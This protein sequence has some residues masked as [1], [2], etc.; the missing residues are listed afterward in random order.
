MIVEAST[1][2]RIDLAGGTLDIYP[3]Y[4][5]EGGAITVN[6]AIDLLSYVKIEE[7]KD[8]KFEIHSEDLNIAIKADNLTS[9]DT[10]KELDL[11]CRAVKY[12]S[13]SKG[14]NIYTKNSVPK[15]SGL[16]ASSSLLMALSGAL[17]IITGKNYNKEQIIDFGA[18]IEAQSLKIPT[19][20][21]DYYAAIYGGLNAICFNMDKVI[22]KPLGNKNI[23]EKL[24]DMIILSYTGESRFSGTN[25]WEMMKRYIDRKEN[26]QENMKN[27]K[28]TSEKMCQAILEEDFEKVAFLINEEWE[29]RKKLAKGVTTE[30]IDKLI[31]GA[32]EKGALASKICGAGGGGCM[33]TIAPPAERNNII[34]ILEEFGAKI[35]DFKINT[36]GLTIIERE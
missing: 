5:F 23:M 19:G 17:N 15:G 25:N 4:V 24:H 8:E 6:L 13:P 32:K 12:Y 10:D 11:I 21:Q 33:I 16:G 22:V 7:R 36:N 30:S 14:L 26:T 1:P 27:I 9:L 3:L 29:N 35:I 31:H 20:K 18:N 2:A 28:D 34:S